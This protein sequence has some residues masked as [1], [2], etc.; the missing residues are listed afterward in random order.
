MGDMVVSRILVVDPDRDYSRL[1][2]VVL[3][4]RD[5]EVA[6][7]GE[8]PAAK[9]LVDEFEPNLALIAVSADHGS[10]GE[11]GELWLGRYA[12]SRGDVSI[13]YMSEHSSLS[14]RLAG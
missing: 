8:L 13:V 11:D 5:C 2:E 14:A 12:Q 7:A 1:L 10:L 4:G 9:R 3:N 6:S